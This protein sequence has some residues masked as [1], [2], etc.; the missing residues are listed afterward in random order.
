MAPFT[1]EVLRIFGENI[2][3]GDKLSSKLQQT[4]FTISPVQQ[5]SGMLMLQGSQLYSLHGVLMAQALPCTP[6]SFL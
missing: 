4:E 6:S 5:Q 3:E 1:E 2:T